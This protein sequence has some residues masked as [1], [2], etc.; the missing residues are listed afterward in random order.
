MKIIGDGLCCWVLTPASS[1]HDPVFCRSVTNYYMKRDD[2]GNLRRKNEPFCLEHTMK[3]RDLAEE[4][5]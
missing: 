3:A 5:E 1:G 2:D 4:A